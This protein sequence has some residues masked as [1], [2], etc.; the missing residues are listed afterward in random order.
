MQ[1]QGSLVEQLREALIAT[2]G[3]PEQNAEPA[4]R[5]ISPLSTAESRRQ[6]INEVLADLTGL[7]ALQRYVDDPTINEVMVVSGR[8]VWVEDADGIRATEPLAP[9]QFDVIVE[10]LLR[11]VGRRIDH[12]SPTVETRLPSGARVCAVISPIAIDGGI[13]C[14]RRF[15]D[16]VLPLRAF[17]Q[18][19]IAPILQHIVNARFNVVISGPTSSGKTSLMAS[20]GALINPRDRVITIEDTAELRIQQP[21]VVRL[22]ARPENS[23]RNGAIDL[24]HLVRT[25]LRLRPDRLIVGEVRGNEVVDMLTAL[26]TGHD[27]S[28]TSVHSNG[29]ANTMIRL[30]TMFLRAIP[31]IDV[32]AVRHLIHSAIDIVIHL[33]KTTDGSRRI[34]DI[35]QISKNN[36]QHR[37]IVSGGVIIAELTERH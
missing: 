17:C 15:S 14:V 11:R 18:Q 4:L 13:L 27:G 8:H 19:D 29:V 26:S 23:E 20:L 32:T 1:T 25:A 3:P 35:V 24:T 37:Q 7:G 12:L 9:G 5:R 6:V 36:N 21:H 22:E 34:T 2:D 28:W 30:E 33:G 10:R 16:N 31:N